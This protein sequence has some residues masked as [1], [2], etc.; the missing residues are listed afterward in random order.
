M[1]I[2]FKRVNL[3]RETTM[4]EATVTVDASAG[5]TGTMVVAV[6][7]AVAKA[8]MTRKELTLNGHSVQTTV[9]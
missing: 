3:L 4:T 5:D 9:E 7:V 8:T 1:F 6:V 2:F